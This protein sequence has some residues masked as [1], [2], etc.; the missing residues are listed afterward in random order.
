MDVD[1]RNDF[2]GENRTKSLCK[3]V[4]SVGVV[5]APDYVN[6]LQPFSIFF[7]NRGFRQSFRAHIFKM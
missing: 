6:Q 1:E 5:F 2:R 7:L 3:S 4:E